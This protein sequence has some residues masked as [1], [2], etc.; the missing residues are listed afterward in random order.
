MQKTIQLIP[1]YDQ[2]KNKVSEGKVVNKCL[3]TMETLHLTSKI[4]DKRNTIAKVSWKV[5][6][7]FYL[8]VKIAEEINYKNKI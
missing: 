5:C 3:R 7:P 1:F 6:V 4:N 8:S 2:N